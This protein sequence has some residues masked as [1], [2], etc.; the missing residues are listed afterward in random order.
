MVCAGRRMDQEALTAK[1]EDAGSERAKSEAESVKPAAEDDDEEEAEEEYD[2][3]DDYSSVISLQTIALFS[4]FSAHQFRF[5][6]PHSHSKR[7]ILR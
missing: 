5:Y 6:V 3:D 7:R 1:T 2:D 4:G